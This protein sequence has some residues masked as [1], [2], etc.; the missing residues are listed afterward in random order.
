[1]CSVIV[2]NYKLPFRVLFKFLIILYAFVEI[3]DFIN[4]QI[5]T[6][7]AVSNRDVREEN[8]GGKYRQLVPSGIRAWNSSVQLTK[9]TLLKCL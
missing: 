1:V 6:W 9:I 2:L 4:F 7:A 5:V 8:C 3:N